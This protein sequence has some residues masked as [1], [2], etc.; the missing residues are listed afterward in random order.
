MLLKISLLLSE[1]LFK[2][3]VCFISTLSHVPSLCHFPSPPSAGG[4]ANTKMTCQTERELL[5]ESRF[6]TGGGMDPLPPERATA[7]PTGCLPACHRVAVL[8]WTAADTCRASLCGTHPRLLGEA[9]ARVGCIASSSS[10]FLPE[11]WH[12]LGLRIGGLSGK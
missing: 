3:F 8:S 6:G 12:L 4:W 11:T 2:P 10:H 5:A 9:S 1:G 7:P